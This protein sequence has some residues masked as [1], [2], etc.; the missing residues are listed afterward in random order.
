MK[1]IKKLLVFTL[2]ML[3]LT[4]CT[5]KQQYGIKINSDKSVELK[6]LIAMDNE[7]IDYSISSNEEDSSIS[8]DD[9]YFSDNN[10]NIY[11][12]DGASASTY[13][14]TYDY[15]VD[16]YGSMNDSTSSSYT[17]EER[18]NYLEENL[19]IQSLENEGYTVEKYE[20]GTDIKGY[21]IK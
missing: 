18:W 20:E 9:S 17:D 14:N 7:A 4:G 5:I 6:I 10:Y 8:Y 21:T 19:G 15:T 1:N 12:Y 16:V 2:C 13:D 11:Y 3:L